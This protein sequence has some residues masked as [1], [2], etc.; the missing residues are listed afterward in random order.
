M[1]TWIDNLDSSSET[2]ASV[3]SIPSTSESSVSQT[4]QSG[5]VTPVTPSKRLRSLLLPVSSTPSSHTT[6]THTSRPP[7]PEIPYN[8]RSKSQP[9]S[10]NPMFHI[11]HPH[12][13]SHFVN[14]HQPTAIK[15]ARLPPSHP[16]KFDIVQIP[17]IEYTPIP[18]L[19]LTSGS[20]NTP[21]IYPSLKPLRHSSTSLSNILDPVSEYQPQTDASSSKIIPTHRYNLRP[22]PNR[23]LSDTDSSTLT[24]STLS[25]NSELRLLRQHAQPI[26]SD[27][28]HSSE[29]VPQ[30]YFTSGVDTA[31]LLSSDVQIA[32][33]SG[34]LF[35]EVLVPTPVAPNVRIP[36]YFTADHS[37]PPTPN[38]S[39]SLSV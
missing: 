2:Y 12:T 31:S 15:S 7:I 25:S 38:F 5:N 18:T 3:S 20:S 35:S 8:T 24:F 19:Q 4:T 6:S 16:H 36:E 21:Q 29:I 27:S 1:I 11:P 10:Y 34:N 32:Y 26:S 28:T 14:Y 30:S 13:V 9:S 37:R 22:L 39:D 33:R 17:D 23:E